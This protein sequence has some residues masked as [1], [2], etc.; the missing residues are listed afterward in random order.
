[1]FL[2]PTFDTILTFSSPWSMGTRGQKLPR[3]QFLL[4]VLWW[5]LMTLLALA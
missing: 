1:M 4:T 2:V 3:N 5:Q